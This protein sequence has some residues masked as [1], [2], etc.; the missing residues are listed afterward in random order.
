MH[1][2]LACNGVSSMHT[3]IPEMP[4]ILRI[5]LSHPVIWAGGGLVFWAFLV[6]NNLVATAGDDHLAAF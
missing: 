1:A 4:I 2:M 3:A 6:H 5:S